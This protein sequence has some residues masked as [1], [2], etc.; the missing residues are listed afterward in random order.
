MELNARIL[1]KN[2]KNGSVIGR[3]VH[4][5]LVRVAGKYRNHV[6]REIN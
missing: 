1:Y 6:A 2:Q 5:L 3:K 4:N